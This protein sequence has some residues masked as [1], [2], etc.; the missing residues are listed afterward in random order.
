VPLFDFSQKDVVDMIKS[1]TQD[2][3]LLMKELHGN[4][5]ADHGDGII[6]TPFLPTFYSSETIELFVRIKGM[7]DP[8]NLFNNKKKTNFDSE[9][10]DQYFDRDGVEIA[11]K[12]RELK[13]GEV[14]KLNK[15]EVMQMVTRSK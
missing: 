6:R 15:E 13:L 4:T 10:I 7:F 3:A 5:S 9:M 14:Y 2:A 11:Q 8:Y 1:F 12:P